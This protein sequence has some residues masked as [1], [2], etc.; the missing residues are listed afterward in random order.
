MK[1]KQVITAIAI[2]LAASAALAIEAT[3]LEDPPPSTLTRDEVRAE[4]ERARDETKLQAPFMMSG[5]E[6][7]VFVDR[8]VASA[9]RDRAEVRAEAIQAAREHAFDERYVGAM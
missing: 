4:M 9:P 3:Q 2:G 6:A 1:F 7:T 5:G 8:P